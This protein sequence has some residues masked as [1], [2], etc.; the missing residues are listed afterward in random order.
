VQVPALTREI[1]A[2]LAPPEVH[3]ASVVVVK[4]TP[5]ADEAV[6]FTV[7]GDCVSVLFASG[8]K[9]ILWEAFD[10]VKLRLTGVAAVRSRGLPRPVVR[11][12]PRKV[13]GSLARGASPA[14]LAR[15]RGSS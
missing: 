5:S 11:V 6:A 2:P 13:P 14:C 7:T 10:T 9:E 1:V 15:A 4:V 3:T 8:P 12:A